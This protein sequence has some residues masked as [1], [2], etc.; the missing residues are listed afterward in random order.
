MLRGLILEWVHAEHVPAVLAV[1]G[2][3][4]VWAYGDTRTWVLH[5]NCQGDPQYTTVVYCDEDPLAVADALTPLL[6]QRWSGG[7]V[8]PLFAGPLRSM[9]EW[10]VWH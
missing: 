5:R 8:R 6:Q 2:V 3:A 10:E 1:P 7:D 9:V 4:G